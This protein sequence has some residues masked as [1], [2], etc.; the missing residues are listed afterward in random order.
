MASPRIRFPYVKRYKLFIFWSTIILAFTVFFDTNIMAQSSLKQYLRSLRW[1]PLPVGVGLALIAF[2]QYRHTRKREAAKLGQL[3]PCDCLADEWE[4]EAYKLLPLRSFSRAWGWVNGLELPE[5]SRKSVLGLFVRTYGCNMAEAEVED[6]N[7]YK[8]LSE[9]FRRTLKDG[10]R[11]LDMSASVVSPVDGRILSFGIV[12][13]GMLDQVKGVSYPLRKFLGPNCWS[14]G[15]PM[16]VNKDD[17]DCFHRSCLRDCE[18]NTLY[19]CV[20]YLAPGDYHRFHSCAD[21]KVNFRRHF[22]GELLSVNPSIAAW[23]RNLFVLNERVTYVGHWKYGF[24]SM[25]AVGATNVGSVR[26]YFDDDLNTNEKKWNSS[27]FHDKY[28]KEKSIELS[29]GGEFGEFNLGSTVVL[30][31]EAPKDTTICVD[32]GQKVR[33]GQALF[34]IPN[35]YVGKARS[36]IVHPG[37]QR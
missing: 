7:K 2:Q 32:I 14:E 34:R 17:D 27:I 1:T 24:L 29:R 23:V 3:E 6:L 4:V 36:E 30:V 22:P 18:N 10:L 25:T 37:P 28:F 5:W 16:V 19:Q 21:W 8:C 15:G 33:M 12:S 26:V 11:P 35:S 31:F 13:C 20:I 9:L